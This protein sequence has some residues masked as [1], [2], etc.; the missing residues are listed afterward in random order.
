MIAELKR[1]ELIDKYERLAKNSPGKLE[2]LLEKRRKRNA[3][4][5]RK[6]MPKRRRIDEQEE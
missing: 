3:A 5:E 6:L 2:R 4:K 1:L